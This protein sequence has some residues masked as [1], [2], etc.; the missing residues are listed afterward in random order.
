MKNQKP[1]SVTKFEFARNIFAAIG[2][3]VTYSF[4]VLVFGKLLYLL[5]AA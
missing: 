1:T 3:T 4:G 2:F 5:F